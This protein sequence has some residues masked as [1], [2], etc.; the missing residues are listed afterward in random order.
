M[1][2]DP[3]Y[4]WLV[5]LAETSVNVSLV[6]VGQSVVIQATSRDLPW[7][8]TNGELVNAINNAI[9]SCDQQLNLAENQEPDRAAFIISPFWVASDGK[10]IDSKL[11]L[12]QDTCKQLSLKPMGFMPY[13]EAIVEEAN[14]QD[15]IPSSFVLT[16]LDNNQ[17]IVSLVFLGKIKR[18]IRKMFTGSFDPMLLESSILEMN[19]ESAL[20]PLINLCGQVD[21]S[22]G[23]LVRNFPWI[24]KKSVE[25]FLHLPEVKVIGKEDLI[26]LFARIIARQINPNLIAPIQTI[27]QAPKVEIEPEPSPPLA[28]VDTLPELT[29]EELGFS[30]IDIPVTPEI[31]APP[32]PLPLLETPEIIP[33]VEVEDEILPLPPPRKFH[34]PL[35]R[36]NP[37]KL[38]FWGYLGIGFI[39]FIS[40]GLHIFAK[41]TVSIFV[42]PYTFSQKVNATLTTDPAAVLSSSL[43]PVQAKSVSVTVSDTITTSGKKVIGDNAKGEIVVF[44]KSDK[45][46]KIPKGSVLTFNTLKFAFQNDTQI[47]SAS[48]DLDKGVITLGQTR[49]VVTAIDIGPEANIAKESLLIFK[50]ATFS[51]LVAKA[52]G[53]FAGGTRQEISAVSQTD[54]NQLISQL[55][56]K[57]TEAVSSKTNTELSSS[58]MAIKGTVTIKKST[59]DFNREVGEQADQL[60]GTQTATINLFMMTPEIQTQIVNMLAPLDPKYNEV[61]NSAGVFQIDFM[62][63]TVTDTTAAGTLTLTGYAPPK[64]NQTALASQLSLK[65]GFQAKELIKK[66]IPRTYDLKI[67]TRDISPLKLIDLLPFT[68]QNIQITIQSQPQ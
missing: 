26:R 35:I 44:N 13:D 34:L 58:Q 16:Y 61:D 7:T 37:S 12:I 40:I 39:F 2:Q 46:V 60:E 17:L 45:T 32:S 42:T 1:D 33:E 51:Q 27:A 67:T 43:I 21:E 25:T 15:G 41:S 53:P 30:P 48:S 36:F 63:K 29:L 5:T 62:V 19:V 24:G 23:N 3:H 20:P 22:I 9:D 49:T 11:R 14:K 68:P 65:T 38:L 47:A 54:K 31:I 8:D 57:V 50:D 28:V 10:I 56:A 55:A 52:S 4:F 6:A 59:V 66:V 18:R 64:I